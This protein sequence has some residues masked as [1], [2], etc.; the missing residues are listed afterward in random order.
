MKTS[1]C[2]FK[3]NNKKE[4]EEKYKHYHNIK[5]YILLYMKKTK[6]LQGYCACIK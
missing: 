4:S 5:I 3:L 6:Q 1:F 2:F